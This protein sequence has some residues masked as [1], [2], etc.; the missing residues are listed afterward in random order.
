MMA[1]V[2]TDLF[3]CPTWRDA[4][5]WGF[6]LSALG[7]EKTRARRTS[8]LFLRTHPSVALELVSSESI[9]VPPGGKA[10]RARKFPG[11]EVVVVRCSWPCHKLD[12]VSV[13]FDGFDLQRY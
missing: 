6:F 12:G 9:A 5:W 3:R 7:S 4:S 10:Q 13:Y 2:M 1:V 8:C 11:M